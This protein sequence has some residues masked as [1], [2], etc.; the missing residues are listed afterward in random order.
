MMVIS[1]ASD[2][3]IPFAAS[4]TKPTIRKTLTS[5]MAPRAKS[6]STDTYIADA[7]NGQQPYAHAQQQ[8]AAVCRVASTISSRK[9][10]EKNK[11]NAVSKASL[12]MLD[13]RHAM[14]MDCNDSPT[15][16]TKSDSPNSPTTA[17]AFPASWKAASSP[18]PELEA[19]T[20]CESY[21][22]PKVRFLDD[23]DSNSASPGDALT[24][25]AGITEDVQ[26]SVAGI[27]RAASF[28]VCD[29]ERERPTWEDDMLRTSVDHQSARGTASS[30]TARTARPSDYVGVDLATAMASAGAGKSRG[31]NKDSTISRLFSW[32]KSSSK[33]KVSQ[34][35]QAEYQPQPPLHRQHAQPLVHSASAP[36]SAPAA[37][38]TFEERYGPLLSIAQPLQPSDSYQLNGSA[39]Y[40]PSNGF[41]YDQESRTATAT[42]VGSG[43]G[44]QPSSPIRTTSAA[45]A[46]TATTATK[47]SKGPPCADE[48]P[49]RPSIPD[50]YKISLFTPYSS[51][52]SAGTVSLRDAR[53]QNKSRRGGAHSAAAEASVYGDGF[54]TREN[55]TAASAKATWNL[56]SDS[57]SS[58]SLAS[59]AN[60]RP[61]SR[62][63]QSVGRGVPVRPTSSRTQGNGGSTRGRIQSVY[64]PEDAGSPGVA[65][66]DFAAWGRMGIEDAPPL[67]ALPNAA[68]AHG[69]GA[70]GAAAAAGK[71]AARRRSRSVGSIVPP[72]RAIGRG[73]GSNNTPTQRDV[74]SFRAEIGRSQSFSTAEGKTVQ[75]RRVNLRQK[76]VKA[77]AVPSPA[78]SSRSPR[79]VRPPL[80]VT[81]MPPTPDVGGETPVAETG[82][83]QRAPSRTRAGAPTAQVPELV[84]GR[85]RENSVAAEFAHM[86]AEYVAAWTPTT[87]SS[88]ATDG[89]IV[90]LDFPGAAH[91]AVVVAS[92]PDLGSGKKPAAAMAKVPAA[93][94]NRPRAPTAGSDFSEAPSE[95]STIGPFGF[96]RSLSSSSLSSGSSSG[97]SFSPISS[98]AHLEHTEDMLPAERGGGNEEGDTSLMLGIAASKRSSLSSA[99]TTSSSILDFGREE[100]QIYE[101]RILQADATGLLTPFQLRDKC[102]EYD[103]DTPKLG[104]SGMSPSPLSATVSEHTSKTGGPQLQLRFSTGLGIGLGLDQALHDV[105]P[106]RAPIPVTAALAIKKGGGTAS[107]GMSIKTPMQTMTPP[108]AKPPKSRARQANKATPERMKAPVGI[109]SSSSSQQGYMQAHVQSAAPHHSTIPAFFVAQHQDHGLGLGLH[110]SH[111]EEQTSPDPYDGY[112]RGYQ[113][114]PSWEGLPR[115]DSGEWSMGVAM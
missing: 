73:N 26:A 42:A 56:L 2:G 3:A 96:S 38:S 59:G 39:A 82:A 29:T 104:N 102:D 47:S 77:V 62:V 11:I 83:F 103:C 49:R 100:A 71:R 25:V 60:S 64:I 44:S 101:E 80:V 54:L 6:K 95:V 87:E 9:D 109:S 113:P 68:S 1:S 90:A 45:S 13:P 99:L 57:E 20:T 69:A 30:D 16:Q 85:Q 37:F 84:Q 108:P 50:T 18:T 53:S 41:Y 51:S 4:P 105:P 112:D 81:V 21:S 93:R 15:L 98:T 115:S 10:K 76:A 36:L 33:S 111:T 97:A 48:L 32:K 31:K 114:K 43:S 74:A 79:F 75:A 72:P 91:G 5:K 8:A 7:T 89:G 46:A 70:A 65:P 28:D 61:I 14:G 67:P 66:F 63:V 12:A 78:L 17:A 35:V 55:S 106:L 52:S 19:F 86:T 23:E 27:H 24:T 94:A 107:S 34:P 58:D 22:T 88:P 92:Q 40:G 110:Q